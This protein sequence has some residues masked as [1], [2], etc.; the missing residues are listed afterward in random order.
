[1]DEQKVRRPRRTAEQKAADIDAKA[2]KRDGPPQTRNLTR[3][4]RR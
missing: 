3:R 1:M 4:R 2:P